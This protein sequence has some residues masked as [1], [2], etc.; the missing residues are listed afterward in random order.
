[1][2][3]KKKKSASTGEKIKITASCFQIHNTQ[4]L[5]FPVV[6]QGTKMS[7]PTDHN[8]RENMKHLLASPEILSHALPTNKD[9]GG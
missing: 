5:Y 9:K 3:K 1:M 8:C 4:G 6:S 7:G 2:L